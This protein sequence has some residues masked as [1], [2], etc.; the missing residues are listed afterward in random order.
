MH[1]REIQ[2]GNSVQNRVC[3]TTGTELTILVPVEA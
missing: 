1:K 3:T 2:I